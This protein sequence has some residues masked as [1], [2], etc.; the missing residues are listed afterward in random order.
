MRHGDKTQHICIST[1]SEERNNKEEAMAAETTALDLK[2]KRK[3]SNTF[4]ERL[5]T[6]TIQTYN[7]H[8]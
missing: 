7:A 8:D 1:I 4:A 6:P 5:T 2:R 3:E